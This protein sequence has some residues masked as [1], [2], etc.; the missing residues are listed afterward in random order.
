MENVFFVMRTTLSTLMLFAR[1]KMKI[2]KPLIILFLNVQNAWKGFILILKIKFV[3]RTN[4]TVLPTHRRIF[5]RN[6]KKLYQ[7]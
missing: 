6:A 5:V 2:V 4:S 7:F 3:I 1:K